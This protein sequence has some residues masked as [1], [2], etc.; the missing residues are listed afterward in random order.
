MDRVEL[1]ELHGDEELLF[2]DPPE[3]FDQCIVGVASRCGQP[4][5]VVYDDKLILAALQN[6]G[7]DEEA[8]QEW[9]SFNIEGAWVGDRTPLILSR[10]GVS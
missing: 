3:Q 7:M 6:A 4:P 2:L 5:V 9:L 8:A 1:C 10:M